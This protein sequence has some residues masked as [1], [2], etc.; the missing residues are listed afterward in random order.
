MESWR[1]PLLII[2]LF[3]CIL[4][5]CAALLP[6]EKRV[7]NTPWASFDAAKAA[8]EKVTPNTTTVK[9]LKSY[10][11]NLYSTPN[12]RI[13]NHLDIA[14]TTI[15]LKMEDLSEGITLCLESR[16]KCTAY[17]F[18]PQIVSGK[19][20]GNFWLDFFNFK[21]KTREN[22]WRFKALFVVVDDVVVEKYWS[23]NP[24]IDRDHEKVNP[25]GPLQDSASILINFFQ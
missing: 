9:E 20:Y 2:L 21:R 22:G 7:T 16:D 8:Y 1:R 18:E 4:S 15:P 14:A 19:R 5:G 12:I 13:M 23:G 6:K 10:G 17:E 3:C 25:L 24:L 11:F